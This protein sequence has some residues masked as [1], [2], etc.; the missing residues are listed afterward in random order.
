[1]PDM[2]NSLRIVLADDHVTVRQGLKLLID[3]QPDM[4]VVGE[5]IDGNEALKHAQALKPDVIVM[6]I[7]MPGTNGL[8][9]TRALKRL[10]P[11]VAVV[12]LT[13]H[14]DDAYLQEL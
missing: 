9:A 5:A 11:T 7:S 13:R 2:A 4:R 3:S 10:H 6:D 1:M 8:I 14:E 12:A